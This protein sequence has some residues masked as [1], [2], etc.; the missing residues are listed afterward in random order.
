MESGI[1]QC[2]HLRRVSALLGIDAAR[3]LSLQAAVPLHH[4][5]EANSDELAPLLLMAPL[6]LLV[7]RLLHL[8]LLVRLVRLDDV[9]VD[10]HVADLDKGGFRPLH[11][12]VRVMDAPPEA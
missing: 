3:L 8:G 9:P 2:T 4:T 12:P 10:V 6:R 11:T 5:L 1:H 7:Q